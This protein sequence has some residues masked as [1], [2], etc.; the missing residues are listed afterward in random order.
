M[1]NTSS[2]IAIRRDLSQIQEL[3]ST[4]N[5]REIDSSLINE[6]RAI[7]SITSLYTY[8]QNKLSHIEGPWTNADISMAAKFSS[9]RSS[10]S[11]EIFPQPTPNTV[12]RLALTSAYCN[13]NSTAD[14]QADIEEAISAISTCTIP[15]KPFRTYMPGVERCIPYQ[16]HS[17]IKV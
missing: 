13:M 1:G 6:R 17:F 8:I 11:T 10:I 9:V 16:G 4:S 5:F 2:G 7:N 3:S 12:M 15:L 14:I